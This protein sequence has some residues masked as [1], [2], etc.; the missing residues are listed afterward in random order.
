MG[1]LQSWADD[2]GITDDFDAICENPK[3]K[4]YILSELTNIAKEK[5][6][7]PCPVSTCI[8]KSSVLNH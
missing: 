8:Q 3:A 6:V 2:N 4:T 1:A 5:K 7:I